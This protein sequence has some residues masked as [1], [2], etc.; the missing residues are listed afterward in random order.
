MYLLSIKYFSKSPVE[1][2]VF[3][4]P[5]QGRT[6]R[7]YKGT[8]PSLTIFWQISSACSNQA[9][10]LCVPHRLVLTNLFDFS[11][12]LTGPVKSQSHVLNELHSI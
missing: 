5:R 3:L 6:S 2:L 10:R 8:R 9:G 1:Y 4:H 11:T 12:A 7:T